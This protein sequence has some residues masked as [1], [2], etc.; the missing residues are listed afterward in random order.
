MKD[1]LIGISGD[2]EVVDKLDNVPLNAEKASKFD[3]S[4]VGASY[5]GAPVNESTSIVFI[6]AAVALL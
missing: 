2:T 3:K 1:G 4:V 5:V 6:T